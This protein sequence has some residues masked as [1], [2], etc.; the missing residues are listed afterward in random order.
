MAATL[1]LLCGCSAITAAQRTDASNAYA[2]FESVLLIE[3]DLQ[4]GEEKD[5]HDAGATA[6]QL[7]QPRDDNGMP[8]LILIP[9]GGLSSAIYRQTIDGRIGWAEQFV[10]A[11]FR[12]YLTKPSGRLSADKLRWNTADVWPLWGIGEVFP[13]R[14]ENSQF[15]DKNVAALTQLLRLEAQP[16]SVPQLSRL[17]DT[18]GD[19][20]VIAHSAG[21]RLMFHPS[22]LAHPNVRGTIAIETLKCPGDG[23]LI[24]AVYA[25]G[26]RWFVGLWGDRLDRGRP[27]MRT[28][29]NSCEKMTEVLR[30]SGVA[31]KNIQTPRDLGV[32]GNS[33]LLMQDSNSGD[34]G[35]LLLQEIVVREARRRN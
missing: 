35:E 31:A 2:F 8:A 27:S 28:R 5:T 6:V 22:I 19:A 29:F 12:V 11:G 13:R 30:A 4:N 23:E 18:T 3:D 16:L 17:L 32:S 34:L 20:I 25:R 21:G 10:T 1:A 33:H 15:P 26:Q 24:S 14:H 7:M 9:G